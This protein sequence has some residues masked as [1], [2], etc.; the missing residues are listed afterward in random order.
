MIR[1][2]NGR[3]KEVESDHW[4]KLF[5]EVPEDWFQLVKGSPEP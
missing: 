4:T 1:D 5:V 3:R 2:E